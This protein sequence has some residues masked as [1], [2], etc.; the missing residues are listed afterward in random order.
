MINRWTVVDGIAIDCGRGVCPRRNPRGHCQLL[1]EV[2]QVLRQAV[3]GALKTRT[4]RKAYRCTQGPRQPGPCQLL[5]SD[6]VDGEDK[7]PEPARGHVLPGRVRR[8]V[9][10]RVGVLFRHPS[11]T[12]AENLSPGCPCHRHLKAEKTSFRR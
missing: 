7:E 1:A 8:R 10:N 12:L 9:A 2:V 11:F 4:Y 5:V 6:F 3:G